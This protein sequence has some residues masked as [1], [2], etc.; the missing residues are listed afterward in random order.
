MLGP[1]VRRRKT[2]PWPS[3]GSQSAWEKMVNKEK[4]LREW[5]EGTIL[6]EGSGQE[7]LGLWME[8]LG[9]VVFGRQ[10]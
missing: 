5:W 1:A 9:P 3:E 8:S 7:R 10:V 6:P 4:T 2:W